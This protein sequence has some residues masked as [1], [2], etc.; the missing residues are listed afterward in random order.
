MRRG[1]TGKTSAKTPYNSNLHF[2][3]REEGSTKKNSLSFQENPQ[4]AH[5]VGTFEGDLDGKILYVL[6]FLPAHSN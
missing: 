3:Y 5:M 6:C 1:Y 2:F 4:L